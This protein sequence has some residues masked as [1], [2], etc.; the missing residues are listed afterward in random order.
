M[1][2]QQKVKAFEKKMGWNKT[3]A[4]QVVLW[5]KG[6]ALLLNKAN[7]KHKLLDLYVEI[8]QLANRNKLKLDSA[9]VRHLKETEKKYKK[10]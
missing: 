10:S 5:L 1:S 2:A 4:G 9:L 7:A 6:D 3:P 8:L